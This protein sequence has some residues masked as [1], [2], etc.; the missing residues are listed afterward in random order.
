VPADAEYHGDEIASREVKCDEIQSCEPGTFKTSLHG[1][2]ECG[3]GLPRYFMTSS[4]DW[5]VRV[6]VPYEEVTLVRGA[7]STIFWL[8]LDLMQAHMSDRVEVLLDERLK[9][10]QWCMMMRQSGY[11]LSGIDSRRGRVVR[12]SIGPFPNR[13]T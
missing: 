1:L 8:V 13:L 3:Y 11:E 7:G 10:I 5:R 12:D 6:R 4:R 9:A 2:D